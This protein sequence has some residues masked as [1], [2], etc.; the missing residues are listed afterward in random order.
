MQLGK[1][2]VFFMLDVTSSRS[3]EPDVWRPQQGKLF[4]NNR[5][6]TSFHLYLRFLIMQVGMS[7]FGN[8]DTYYENIHRELNSSSSIWSIT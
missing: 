5:K 7:N 2:F 3:A 4:G 1:Q 6:V 8:A